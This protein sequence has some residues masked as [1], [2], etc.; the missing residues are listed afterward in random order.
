MRIVYSVSIYFFIVAIYSR[1]ALA[2]SNIDLLS[3]K[4]QSNQTEKSSFNLLNDSTREADQVKSQDLQNSST[5]H[6]KPES[7]R[8]FDSVSNNHTETDE[9][10]DMVGTWEGK[11]NIS[12]ISYYIRLSCLDGGI[13][14]GIISTLE[15]SDLFGFQGCDRLFTTSWKS[16]GT[17]ISIPIPPAE[18]SNVTNYDMRGN[19]HMS[20]QSIGAE[21]GILKFQLN[22]PE[23]LVLQSD[24][25]DCNTPLP[26]GL[27]PDY[28]DRLVLNKISKDQSVKN[29]FDLHTC[30]RNAAQFSSQAY[31]EKSDYDKLAKTNAAIKPCDTIRKPVGTTTNCIPDFNPIGNFWATIHEGDDGRYYLAFKGTEIKND[32]R[33]L[34]ADAHQ[35]SGCDQI[36]Y[37]QAIELAT[38]YQ[39]QLDPKREGKLI[40]TGHSLGGGLAMAAALKTYGYAITFNTASINTLY[41]IGT[42][43]KKILNYRIK[44]DVVISSAEFISKISQIFYNIL[45]SKTK[46]STYGT[47]IELKLCS[48]PEWIDYL[49]IFNYIFFHSIDRFTDEPCKPDGSVQESQ[50]ISERKDELTPVF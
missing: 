33:D 22:S 21:S 47:A 31:K 40:I 11:C 20:H 38:F 4:P 29:K 2:L 25:G 18:G 50:I 27:T 1:E 37:D 48:V 6:N 45:F 19:P 43:P 14:S 41:S 17:E 5:T 32:I 7:S 16:H 10:L 26:I 9:N 23:S 3:S 44:Q 49:P 46:L 15:G 28:P 12:G 36:Q 13:C 42:I 24:S 30:Y 35:A 8:F 39:K 34:L